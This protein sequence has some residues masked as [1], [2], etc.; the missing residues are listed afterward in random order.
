M[1]PI[2][3]LQHSFKIPSKKRYSENILTPVNL[4]GVIMPWIKE[5]SG[6]RDSE[7]KLVCPSG[8]EYFFIADSEWKNILARYNWNQ[9][10]VIGLLN[11]SN[12]TLIPQKVIP[13]NPPAEM[14]NVIDLAHWKGRNLIKKLV[15]NM[16]DLVVAPTA[17]QF[18]MAT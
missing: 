5:M 16:N 8:L 10:K 4:T 12:M 1:K 6:E 18:G 14:E 7:F 17:V 9:V 3:K 2:L 11:V 13:T 15:K